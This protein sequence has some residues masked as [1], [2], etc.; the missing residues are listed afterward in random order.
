[1]QVNVI[2]DGIPSSCTNGSCSFQFDPAITPTVL[3]IT[4]TEG[5]KGTTVVITGTKFS[6]EID[7]MSVFI[8][9]GECDVI[10]SNI[11]SVTCIASSHAAGSYQVRVLVEGVGFSSGEV[12]FHYLLTLDS[13]TPSIGGISGG[14]EVTITGKGF[15]ELSN[16][17]ISKLPWI[18]SGIGLPLADD[19][20]D[21]NF[22]SLQPQDF[23][24]LDKT[25]ME[26]IDDE[27]KEMFLSHLLD[28]EYSVSYSNGVI[29]NTTCSL[30]ID[31][32]VDYLQASPYLS[33][34]SVSIGG[35][36]CIISQ[37]NTESLNCTTLFVTP[38]IVNVT[39]SVF[40]ETATLEDSFTA[41][42]EYTPSVVSIQPEFSAVTGGE[43]L[44]IL[45]LSFSISDYNYTDE[46]V[47][48]F[49]GNASCE[50]GH[51]NESHIM[52]TLGPHAPGLYHVWIS[53]PNGIAVME[54]ILQEIND[55]LEFG[56]SYM[57]INCS[58]FPLHE[59][60]LWAGL[61]SSILASVAGGSQVVIEGGVYIDSYTQLYIGGLLVN[62]AHLHREKLVAIMPSTRKTVH[63]K[64]NARRIG[65]MLNTL[66]YPSPA[67]RLVI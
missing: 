7:Q 56:W 34:F 63:I 16:I 39:V 64:L 12:C 50:I 67:C 54:N 11:T 52:C 37:S 44:I 66:L 31:S 30:N 1:M 33:L 18:R 28:K 53:S 26:D 2:I 4:P 6:N 14:Y 36:P 38:G 8:G 24:G 57:T 62:I 21:F 13:I 10:N 20:D 9:K 42:L 40:S 19:F 17:F 59:Y 55:A 49:V 35:H 32:L 61:S 27:L 60:R 29:A 43:T 5:Q 48:V 3:S 47:T 15:L 65:K 25:I 45:R 46:D 41:S 23:S 22:C 51:A 58:I